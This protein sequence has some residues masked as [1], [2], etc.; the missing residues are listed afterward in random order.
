M[1]E[2]YFPLMKFTFLVIVHTTNDDWGFH[3]DNQI[4]YK[5]EDKDKAIAYGKKYVENG[6]EGTY[7]VLT[8]QGDCLN[9]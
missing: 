6:H 1:S 4:A 5:E 2:H 7:A 8:N 9:R 3:D